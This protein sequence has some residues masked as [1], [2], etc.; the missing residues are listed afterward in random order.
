MIILRTGLTGSILTSL[1]LAAAQPV[2]AQHDISGGDPLMILFTKA[3]ADANQM[4]TTFMN[5]VPSRSADPGIVNWL[6]GKIGIPAMRRGDILAA[7]VLRSI[8][9]WHSEDQ[10]FNRCAGTADDA[11]S[12]NTGPA[13]VVHLFLNIC[14]SDLQ[15]AKT[16]LRDAVE[17][18]IHE[19]V[20][21][22]QIDDPDHEAFA[23]KVAVVIVRDWLLKR[24]LNQPYWYDLS[25]A[26]LPEPRAYHSTVWGVA[27]SQ[28]DPHEFVVMWGG[29]SGEVLPHQ[30]VCDSYLSSGSV[31]S[32]RKTG[33]SSPLPRTTWTTMDTATAPPGRSRHSAVFTGVTDLA[34][35]SE[36]MIIFGGCRGSS[37]SCDQTLGFYGCAS[38]LSCNEPNAD[39][40]SYDLKNDRWTALNLD[41]APSARVFHSAVWANDA[42]IV[43]G[44]LQGY[45]ND[46]EKTVLG[47]GGI[48]RFDE[49]HP[50]GRWQEIP[51][52]APGAPMARFGHTALWT[53]ELMIIWGGCIEAGDISCRQYAN[54]GAIFNPATGVFTPMETPAFLSG[55][56]EHSATLA[57]KYMVIYGGRRSGT[58]GLSDGAIYDISTGEWTQLSGN[59]PGIEM[60]RYGHSAEFDSLRG[61]ILFWGG[62]SAAR[63]FSSDT[64][65]F[66][67]TAEGVRPW[68]VVP[69]GSAPNGRIGHTGVWAQDALVIWGGFSAEGKF[70]SSGA[71]LTP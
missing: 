62:Q 12:D 64:L 44:G 67:L 57:G 1:L 42:M 14:R 24:Q 51:A 69:V 18:L 46:V 63:V 71:V 6:N 21:H 35:T 47:N 70:V 3:Q 43:W 56:I 32:I 53:G 10:G 34:S 20:H 15:L 8:H 11:I 60:R 28:T 50:G 52:D 36:R 33:D 59:Q 41:G 4:V 9:Q 26:N 61:R 17:T 7:D 48:L 54:D 45:Q 40:V 58:N 27:G 65:A 49:Q 16:P 19:S 66:D 37:I 13:P 5:G 38:G 31:V 55:R 22:F 39:K 2:F 25:V 29:C 23:S 68:S 30:N